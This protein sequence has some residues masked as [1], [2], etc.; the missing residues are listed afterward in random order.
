[1]VPFE[2]GRWLAEHIPGSRPHLHPDEGHLSLGVSGLSRIMDDLL[3][4]SH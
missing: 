2:H 4:L 3:E 1:M